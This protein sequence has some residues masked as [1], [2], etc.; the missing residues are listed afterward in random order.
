MEIARRVCLTVKL[1]GRIA[2][3]VEGSVRFCPA[4]VYRVPAGRTSGRVMFA[5]CSAIGSTESGCVSLS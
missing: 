4:R 3:G 2:P 5:T 1:G